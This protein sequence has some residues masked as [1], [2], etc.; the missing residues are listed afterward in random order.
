MFQ[1]YEISSIVS[2]AKNIGFAFRVIAFAPLLYLGLLNHRGA[3]Y[4]LPSNK[5]LLLVLLG[6]YVLLGLIT[7][8]G[9]KR[10]GVDLPASMATV[11]F[12]VINASLFITYWINGEY[13]SAWIFGMF[14]C[15]AIAP[16]LIASVQAVSLAKKENDLQVPLRKF[17]V[18]SRFRKRPPRRATQWKSFW[19]YLEFFLVSMI[20]IYWFGTVSERIESAVWLHEHIMIGTIQYGLTAPLFLYAFKCKRLAER[21]RALS[22]EEATQSDPRLPVLLLRAFSD[23]VLSVENRSRLLTGPMLLESPAMD[24]NSWG[25]RIRFEEV[26][27]NALWEKAPVVAIGEPGEEIPETGAFRSYYSDASWQAEVVALM[28]RARLVLV[29]LSGSKSVQWEMETLRRLGYMHK[30][31][32]LLPPDSINMQRERWN[33]LAIYGD[34]ALQQSFD[35]S[36]RAVLFHEKKWIAMKSQDLDELSL[37]LLAK[38]IVTLAT[39]RNIRG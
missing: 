37:T 21:L 39:D 3:E 33:A 2:I 12:L 1:N 26:I 28:N 15:A 30:V 7:W 8:G 24:P 23:D 38:G 22:I 4:F 32:F 6:L 11:L 27:V 19:Q 13:D 34:E 16:I 5:S 20:A 14:F 9:W 18:Q 29:V 25:R 36:I 31:V 35:P 17:I 10:L